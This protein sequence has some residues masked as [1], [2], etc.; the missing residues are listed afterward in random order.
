MKTYRYVV[1]K[2]G[3]K[4]KVVREDNLPKKE[5]GSNNLLA[6]IAVG[7]PVVLFLLDYLAR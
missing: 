7:V 1:L 3:T 6:L 4:F 5:E 2:D